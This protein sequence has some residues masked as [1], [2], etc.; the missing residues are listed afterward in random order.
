MEAPI[1]VICKLLLTN[2][3]LP[4]QQPTME[5]LCHCRAHTR[6][7]LIDKE[8]KVYEDLAETCPGCS[9]PYLPEEYLMEV[10][11]Q[12]Q[13]V[14]QLQQQRVRAENPCFILHESSPEFL[15]DVD[16]VKAICKELCPVQKAFSTLER[17][18]CKKFRQQ[19]TPMVSILRSTKRDV[20]RK[21]RESDE[22]KA[23]SKAHR[24]LMAQ[25]SKMIRRYNP[26]PRELRSYFRTHYP[27]AVQPRM[28]NGPSMWSVKYK[29]RL[30]I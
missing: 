12:A 7:F 29:F 30:R 5:L 6:C 22:Y 19:V 17:E 28:W 20:L 13:Q 27:L 21:L 14:R 4:E 26:T 9:H 11:H 3:E 1:C 8:V 15:Q 16:A 25:T 2:P 18:A 10:N 23:Y 24:K